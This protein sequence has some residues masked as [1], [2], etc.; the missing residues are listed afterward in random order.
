M[1]LA[2]PK[3]VPEIVSV[4][5]RPGDLKEQVRPMLIKKGKNEVKGYQEV[6]SRLD[7]RGKIRK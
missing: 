4:C 3:G 2:R 7:F 6:S 1:T 5:L